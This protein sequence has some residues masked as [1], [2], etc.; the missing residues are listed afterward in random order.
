VIKAIGC[1]R[2]AQDDFVISFTRHTAKSAMSVILPITKLYWIALYGEGGRKDE[3]LDARD[4]LLIR[5]GRVSSQ[6][7]CDGREPNPEW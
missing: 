6:C 5:S 7:C 1:A 3:V 2:V 4:R